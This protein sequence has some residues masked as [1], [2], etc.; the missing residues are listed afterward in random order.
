MK[1]KK[2][3]YKGRVIRLFHETVRLPNGRRTDLDMIEH[4]GAV[5]IVPF[6]D[7][8]RIILLRQYRATIK[9]YLYELPAG[10][11]NRGEM[12]LACARREVVEETGFAAARF[13][14]LGRIV[15]V[16]GYA[17]EKI[18]IYKATHLT[19]AYRARDDDEIIRTLVVTRLQVRRLLKSRRLEDAKTIAALAF[20]GW[21]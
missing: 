19:P 16:P 13:A 11:L 2:L 10:T 7:A 3:I 21:L 1:S 8:R 20:C 6:L 9:R 14:Y 12:P 4:P 18:F 17:D 15:P 5:L